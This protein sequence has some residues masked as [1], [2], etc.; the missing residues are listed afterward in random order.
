M[1]AGWP[2]C[3]RISLTALTLAPARAV[4]PSE[5]LSVK[6]LRA[7]VRQQFSSA[8]ARARRE[9]VLPQGPLTVQTLA[10]VHAVRLPEA[11]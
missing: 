11:S 5:A 7:P 1:L 8:P 3:R 6:R 4:I 9:A 10:S 2:R